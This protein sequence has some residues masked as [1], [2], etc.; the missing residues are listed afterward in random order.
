MITK[1]INIENENWVIKLTEKN[2]L[3]FA[4]LVPYSESIYSNNPLWYDW[5]WNK[6]AQADEFENFFVRTGTSNLNIFKIKATL[7]KEIVKFIK[8]YKI[9]FFYFQP[10]TDKKAHIYGSISKKITE[11]LGST[12]K[13][14]YSHY[15]FYFLNTI[16]NE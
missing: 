6:E 1:R 14:Q 3:S 8:Q 5:G 15:W 13:V 10:N 11:M 4:Y 16:K 9:N 2:E 12:W 7:M